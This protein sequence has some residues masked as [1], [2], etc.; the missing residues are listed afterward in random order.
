V[1]APG[2]TPSFRLGGRV[3]GPVPAQPQAEARS[4]VVPQDAALAGVQSNLVGLGVIAAPGR[5][6]GARRKKANRHSRPTRRGKQS[7]QHC[8]SATLHCVRTRMYLSSDQSGSAPRMRATWSSICRETRG[9]SRQGAP[10][11]DGHVCSLPRAPAASAHP[12]VAVAT[13]FGAGWSPCAHTQR[14]ASTPPVPGAVTTPHSHVLVAE[15]HGMLVET[16]A[17]WPATGRQSDSPLGGVTTLQRSLISL[18]I[19][20]TTGCTSGPV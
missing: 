9:L 14:S 10:P 18:K 16:A 3:G 19:L 4:L 20:K 11:R 5:W 7:T 6:R 15:I 12:T 13:P 17:G 8:R 1:G 2:V